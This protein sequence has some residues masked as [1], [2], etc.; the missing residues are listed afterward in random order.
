MNIKLIITIFGLALASVSGCLGMEQDA[1]EAKDSAP[2]V[3]TKRVSKKDLIGLLCPEVQNVQAVIDLI[4]Q[5]YDIPFRYIQSMIAGKHYGNA[6]CLH[7][8]VLADIMSS[9]QNKVV[10]ELGAARGEN[11]ILI[12]LAGACQ[13][14]INDINEEELKEGEKVIQQL[15]PHMQKKFTV[16]P[17]DCFKAFSDKRFEGKFDVIYARNLFHFFVGQTREKFVREVSRLLKPGGRLI[18]VVNSAYQSIFRDALEKQPSGYV[19]ARRTPM[20]RAIGKTPVMVMGYGEVTVESDLTMVDPSSFSWTCL[21][22]LV[23]E[24]MHTKESFYALLSQDMQGKVLAYASELL[25]TKTPKPGDSIDCH[26]AHSICY[27]RDTMRQAFINS[28]FELVKALSLDYL[29]HVIDTPDNEYFL[30]VVF[31]KENNGRI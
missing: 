11:G 5:Y 13:V 30:S 14:Y 16:V 6:Y 23:N 31:A 24:Q 10:L 8:E 9:S 3:S 17:G 12:G 29:C 28:D 7:P 2:H 18:L 1:L 15:P 26:L 19:F 20:Y 4:D 22:A 25:R 27:T 21:I